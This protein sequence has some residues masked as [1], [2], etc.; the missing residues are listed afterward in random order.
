ML[1]RD[2]FA[3][4]SRRDYSKK[5]I[6]QKLLQKKYP[7]DKIASVLEEFSLEGWQ[8]D[9]RFAESFV[10][11]RVAKGF[12]PLNILLGLRE[13]GID[14]NLAKFIVFSEDYDWVE[15]AKTV[16]MKKNRCNQYDLFQQKRFLLSRGFTYELIDLAIS[17]EG[18]S[19][20]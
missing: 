9:Q 13:K 14:E 19:S 10:R 3:L 12:G 7:H 2:M 8:S 11:F 4:L 15:L 20:R 17:S 18:V 1:R 5:E 6:Y 16:L